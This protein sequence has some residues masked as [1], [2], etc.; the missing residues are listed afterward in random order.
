[1][2]V[3]SFTSD[4]KPDDFT[5]A[6]LNHIDTATQDAIIWGHITFGAN[7]IKDASGNEFVKVVRCRDCKHYYEA[8]NYHPNGNYVRRCCKYFDTYNDEVEPDGFCAW[9]EKWEK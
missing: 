7:L 9:G 5:M 2:S 4:D 6:I 3:A 1:M 8:E